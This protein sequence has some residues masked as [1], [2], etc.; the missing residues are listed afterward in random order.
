MSRELEKSDLFN[1]KVRLGY[2][3]G[4]TLTRDEATELMRVYT[5]SRQDTKCLREKC[6]CPDCLNHD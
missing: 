5:R 1:I 3:E 6:S 2:K 4:V